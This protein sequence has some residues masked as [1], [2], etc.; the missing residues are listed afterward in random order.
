VTEGERWTREE[1]RRL[2]DARFAP[3]AIARFLVA[4]QRRANEIRRA[5]P[6]LARQEARWIAGGALAWLAPPVRDHAR[7]GLAWW[8]L[9]ALMLDWHLGMLETPEGEPRPLGP[10]DALT[11]A[12]A[13]A[14]PLAAR[15]PTPALIAAAAATDVLDG[16]AARAT[17]PTRAGRDLEGLVDACFAG[18]ALRGL[19]RDGRLHRRAVGLEAARLAAGAAYGLG[20]YFGRA[21]RPSDRV[22][23]AG[24][25]AT[26]A[27]VGGLTAGAAGRPRLGDALLAAS[28][29]W[30]VSALAAAGRASS[31]AG[32]ATPR[33]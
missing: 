30:S 12:R 16:H 7:A 23:R 6:D 9:T 1:L 17:A 15:R 21:E 8:S 3:R 27:R 18:A 32:S 2:L 26:C 31:R 28:T 19:V 33:A 20:V 14:V 5:R 11:L 22:L 29:A 25:A 10:A 24:R 4:S 13:W